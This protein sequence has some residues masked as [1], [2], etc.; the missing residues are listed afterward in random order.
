MENAAVVITF[1]SAEI[2][3]VIW[4]QS[5]VLGCSWHIFVW[6]VQSTDV[7]EQ[8]QAFIFTDATSSQA[9]TM[10]RPRPRA[11]IL[12]IPSQQFYAVMWPDDNATDPITETSLKSII[13]DFKNDKL[14]FVQFELWSCPLLYVIYVLHELLF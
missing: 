5:Y 2:Q 11:I 12:D 10:P 7:V 8:L 13:E 3:F 4:R 1:W 6:Y 14:P 9:D